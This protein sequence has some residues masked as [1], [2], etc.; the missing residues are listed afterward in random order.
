MLLSCHCFCILSCRK[1]RSCS[2]MFQLLRQVLSLL[3]HYLCFFQRRQPTC[4]YLRKAFLGSRAYCGDARDEGGRI[5]K[6]QVG[7]DRH[8]INICIN[9]KIYT[10]RHTSHCSQASPGRVPSSQHQRYSL[11]SCALS[12]PQPRR[13]H[14][15]STSSEERAGSRYRH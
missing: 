14:N 2:F 11:D 1:S 8:I 3:V 7:K 5:A 13:R 4:L 6:L 15:N 9:C 12:C 10:Q